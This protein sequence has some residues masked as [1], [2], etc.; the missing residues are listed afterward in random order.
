MDL[1][2]INLEEVP[3]NYEAPFLIGLEGRVP[4]D[5]EHTILA[6]CLYDLRQIS[7]CTVKATSDATSQNE[8]TRKILIQQKTEITKQKLKI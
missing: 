3:L 2:V 6:C 7:S 5:R 8:V 1:F 4:A